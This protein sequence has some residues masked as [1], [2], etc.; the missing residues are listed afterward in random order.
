MT[1]CDRS[2]VTFTVIEYRLK[3]NPF[4]CQ[5]TSKWALRGLYKKQ[6]CFSELL[7]IRKSSLHRTELEV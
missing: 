3:L 5:W 1:Q 7:F 6:T 2:L 4:V